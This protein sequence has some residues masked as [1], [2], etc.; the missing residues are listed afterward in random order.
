MIRFTSLCPAQPAEKEHSQEQLCPGKGWDAAGVD[1]VYTG[2]FHAG[3]TIFM[4]RL[5]FT[6]VR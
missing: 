6:P 2:A 5:L 3:G 1:S 4:V